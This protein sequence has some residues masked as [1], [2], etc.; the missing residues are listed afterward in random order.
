MAK[1]TFVEE[2]PFNIL[3]VNVSDYIATSQLICRANK[4]TGFYMMQTFT[5]VIH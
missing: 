1:N 3:T 5:I 4:L 2:V